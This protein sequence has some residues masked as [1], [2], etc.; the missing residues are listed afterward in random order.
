MTYV[1]THSEVNSSLQLTVARE[2][3]KNYRLFH[4]A[5][6]TSKKELV[7][8]E[9]AAKPAARKTDYAGFS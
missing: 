3:K 5:R 7:P 8:E 6:Q 4:R 1:M 2:F 9:I